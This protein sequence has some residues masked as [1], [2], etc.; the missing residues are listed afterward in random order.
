MTYYDKILT[1]SVFDKEKFN[2]KV[3]VAA[4]VIYRYRAD[5]IKEY[6]LIQRAAD[7]HYPLHW[8]FPR[9]K[10]DGGED[11]G[12]KSEKPPICA[13]R[14]IKEETGLD[15]IPVKKIGAHTYF[16]HYELAEKTCHVYLCQMKN[17]NQEVKLSKE[18]DAY[19]WVST[20][21]E[22]ELLMNPD[23]KKFILKILDVDKLFSTPDTSYQNVEE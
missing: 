22:L 3:T 20:S 4:G 10:C 21:G 6:L 1:E 23:Q 19:R 17:P 5:G 14:E 2:K 13:I 18:H 8:E 7:D 16:S 11:K 9:G 15:I 12:N